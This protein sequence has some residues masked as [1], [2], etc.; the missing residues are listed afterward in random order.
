MILTD[1][2][3]P[4]LAYIVPLLAIAFVVARN[5][6]RVYAANAALHLEALEGGV[7]APPSLHPVI[8][9]ARCIGCEA[10]VH[11]CP[12]FPAHTVLGVVR[13][14]A[15][16]VSP[17]D[18]IGHGACKTACPVNAIRLVFGT[19]ERGVDI[20][21]VTP[22]FETNVEGLY[23]AGELGGMGLIRNAVEQGRQAVENI[24]ARR[25]Q[26]KRARDTRDLLIVGAGPAGFSATLAAHELGLD[27]VTVEQDLLGGTVA[28]FP[29]GKLVMTAPARLALVGTMSFK[30]VDKESLMRFWKEAEQQTGIRINYQERVDTID[31]DGDAFLVTTSKAKYRARAV[32]LALGRRG[33]PRQL[34]VPGEQLPKVVYRLDDPE[35]YSGKKVLVVGGGDSALEAALAVAE[36]PR[37][38]VTVSYRSGAFSRVKQRNR[39]LVKQA[40]ELGRIDLKLQTNVVAIEPNHVVL[41][42]DDR[43]AKLAN[44]Q[45]IICAG[46][47]LP[48]DFLRRVGIHIETKY[49]TE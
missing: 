19:A 2:W 12:E 47:V 3:I 43:P 24:A 16:L 36:T 26:G 25:L 15:N 29:R 44:D 35:Q 14:K 13:G 39:N 30:E 31:A 40:S 21:V 38:H 34:G 41:E 28:H 33:T 22:S 7:V 20:P 11:A 46:G 8:D 27:Y 23:V 1:G 42:A 48:T 32:L 10:C 4:Y 9:H 45:V 17:S 18:C 5:R 49:G 6:R 37:S